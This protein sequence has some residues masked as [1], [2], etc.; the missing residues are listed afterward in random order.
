MGRTTEKKKEKT[1]ILRL[2]GELYELVKGGA[3]GEGKN[4]SE[5]I[6][7]ILSRAG[8]QKNAGKHNVIQKTNPKGENSVIQ[9]MVSVESMMDE[10]LYKDLDQM[11]RLSGLTIGRFMEYIRDM[12]EE[13][14]IYI[15]GVQVKV[16]GEYELRG[17]IDICYRMNV[18]P[19]DMI[20]KLVRSLQRG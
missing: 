4:L 2:D 11:C 15:E 16:K 5:Y 3:E 9:N 19:Q 14:K 10:G 17:L 7:E 13:G 8:D 20:D 12:F 1:V 6:R 18:D